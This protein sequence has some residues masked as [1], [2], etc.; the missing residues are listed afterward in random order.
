M[1]G[2]NCIILFIGGFFDYLQPII[3]WKPMFPVSLDRKQSAN[4][5]CPQV[6]QVFTS[7]HPRRL[8]Q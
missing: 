4:D 1:E 2:I 5:A 7:A 8:F 6:Y 3:S